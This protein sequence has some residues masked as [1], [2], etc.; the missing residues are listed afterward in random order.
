MAV[1]TTPEVGD[2]EGDYVNTGMVFLNCC[3]I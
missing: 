1:N 2:K 3:N